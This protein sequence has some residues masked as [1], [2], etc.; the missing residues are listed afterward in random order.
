MLAEAFAPSPWAFGVAQS[1]TGRNWRLRASNPEAARA[2]ARS[3]DL[4]PLLCDLLLARGIGPNEAA[5]YLNPTLKRLLPEPLLLSDMYKA[6]ERA[7]AAV[8]RGEQI[9]V[10]GD[11]DVD[12]SCAAALLCEFLTALGRTPR[13]YIPDR[14][15]EGY[16]PNAPAFL[17]LKEEGASLVFTV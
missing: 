14:M 5:D 13:I 15:T 2:L 6:V 10:F 16:G 3:A 4:S 7:R 9:A 12:G 17:K 11:Y 1:F 8:E